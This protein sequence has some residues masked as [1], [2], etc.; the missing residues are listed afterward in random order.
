MHFCDTQRK[1]VD[2]SKIDFR[3]KFEQLLP[4]TKTLEIFELRQEYKKC[5]NKNE[6]KITFMSIYTM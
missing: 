6:E 3:K 4:N 2:K 1:K 5:I